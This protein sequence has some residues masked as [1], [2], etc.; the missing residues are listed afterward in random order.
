MR[1]L[2]AQL[3]PTIGDIRGN[4]HKV[5]EALKR[6]Q[7]ENA[8][9][10]LFSELVVSGYPPEDLLLDPEF[11]EACMRSLDEI[12]LFTKGLFAVVGLPR[13]NPSK[14]EKPLYNSA[15]VF[16]NG[17]L[18]GFKNKTLLPTYDVF[19]E[20]RYFEPG[21]SD[22]PTWDYL[23]WKIAVTICED[24]WQHS[25]SGVYTYYLSDPITDLVEKKPDLL[26]N[27]SASPYA[28]QKKEKRLAVFQ[29]AAKTLKCP[30]IM[31]NQVGA[32][33]QIV[34]D[35]DSI[36]LNERGE[37]IQLAKGFEED[38]LIVDL[39][40]HAC[41]C[42]LAEN[43]IKDLHS[44]LVLGI[45]DYFRKQGFVKA[46]LGLSGGIDSAVVA[47][48]AAEALGTSHVSALSMPTRFSSPSSWADA[49]ELSQSL[50]IRLERVEI[51][52]IFQAYLDLLEPHFQ[53][54]AF[55]ET[56]ENM[57]SRIRGMVLMAF[58]NKFGAL[59]L[60]T[61]NK[62]E[63]AMGYT[64]LYG[65]MCGGIGVLIDVT[66]TRVY[67]LARWINREK[68][69]IPLSIVSKVPTAEL[70]PNQTDFDSLPRFE[71][72][73][74]VIEDYI[75]QR[76]APS[77]IAKKRDLSLDFV[78]DLIKKIHLAEYKRRQAPIGI[79][80]TPKSFSKGR[81]VPIAQTWNI[82]VPPETP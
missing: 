72:L 2:A 52:S 7:K 82:L 6:A 43:P 3:N 47:C 17:E 81:N 53:G 24:A 48:L 62:S 13:W 50:G 46:L 37:L 30:L 19:D 14:R 79:R 9:I 55:D 20:R 71:I 44:A 15:A 49:F 21:A 27:L 33:D 36:Y 35:G 38:D 73:D 29:A 63:M 25:H 57:Q 42:P 75:E 32:N 67:E 16:I 45:R 58:S 61:G 4:T 76:L 78:K 12:A 54:R 10:V 39:Q 1:V 5:I 77:E 40:T 66:K 8:D 18:A 80:V 60:N 64:T 59:V 74:P 31:C 22:Q 28:F 56:E 51:D 70:R 26:L 65:D 41:A 69:I 23:G 34:F 68:E 11:I